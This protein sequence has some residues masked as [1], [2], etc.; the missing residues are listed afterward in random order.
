MDS[1]LREILTDDLIAEVKDIKPT[2][3]EAQL[4]KSLDESDITKF[5]PEEKAVEEETPI[6]ET[7]VEEATVEEVPAEEP[8]P[9]EEPVK[10][11][12]PVAEEEKAEPVVVAINDDLSDGKRPDEET[13][14]KEDDKGEPGKPEVVAVNN[15][16]EEPAE[17]E[18]EPEEAP[19]EEPVSEEE[20]PAEE[21]DDEPREGETPEEAEARRKLKIRGSISEAVGEAGTSKVPGK[22]EVFPEDDEFKYRL[23]ANNGEILVVSYGY[24]TREG[25]HAGIDTLKKNLESGVVAYITDK[26]GRSQWRLSTGNDARIVALGETYSSLASA[27]SAFASTQKFGK[28]DRIID[29]DEIP[30]K[31]RRTWEFTAEVEDEKD[32]GTI[33]IY[34]D[35]GKFRARLLANNQ[36]VLF[37]TAQSYSSKA[38]LKSSLENIKEKLGPKA[39][40]LSKDKQDRYQ[41]I[42]ESGSGFVYLVGESYSAGATAKSAAGSVLAFIN[43]AEVVDLTLKSANVDVE[44]TGTKKED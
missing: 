6:E 24:T 2:E 34:D 29:L 11:E 20:K 43:K 19:T 1:K 10:E 41:F 31:E 28:A 13:S 39:F 14:P 15:L 35:N 9:E 33:E 5:T 36:E 32:S 42:M 3:R 18:P 17:E 37:V 12:E 4:L 25:A 26:N 40:H 22:F 23:K 16:D 30:A 21:A 27:Q 7:P 38:S 44:L 8:A